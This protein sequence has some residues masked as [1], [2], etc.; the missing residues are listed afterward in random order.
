VGQLSTA[1]AGGVS[2]FGLDP[3]GYT[4]H[5]LHSTDRSYPETN[6]YADV[7]VELL[8]AHGD[9]PLAAM[10]ITLRMDFEGDQWTF[11]KPFPADLEQLF[12]VDIHEMQPYRSLPQQIE[13]Q[14]AAGRTMIVELDA[15][16]LPDTASTSYRREHVKT[17]VAIES[18]DRAGERMRYFHNAGYHTLEG[19]DYRGIFRL[20]GP[21]ADDVLPPYAEIARFDS[22]PQLKGEELRATALDV[23]RGHLARRPADNPFRRFGAQLVERLPELLEG[24]AQTY[25]DYAFATVRMAGSAFEVCASYVEWVLGERGADA[26]AAMRRIVETCKVLSFRL[27]RRRAF[28]PQGYVDELAAAWDEAMAAL[29]AAVR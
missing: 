10:G 21:V 25:H 29:D 15:W 22:G 11:F 13:E 12:G 20:D 6:C 18:I 26:A 14:I 9:E 1:T 27:A 19:E 8:H 3:E 17:S 24:D 16:Y 28:E 7:L 2:L 23:M 5:A 4:P